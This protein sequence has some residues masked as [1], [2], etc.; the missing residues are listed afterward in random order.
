MTEI[1]FY[2]LRRKTL[3]EALPVILERALGRDG[4]VLVL[5]GS[6]ER[7]EALSAWLWTFRENSF[8]PHGT[9]RDGHDSRQPI[10]LTHE[11]VNPNAAKVLVQCDGAT[12][13]QVG[14]FTLVCDLFD[15]NDPSAVAAA[16]ERWR[17]HKDQGRQLVYF[18]QDSAGKWQQKAPA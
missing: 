6:A 4:R 11:S 10:Y 15:G 12:W 13:G 9:A 5:V 8:L 14:E 16:R 17:E 1:R 2:H 18:Q 7:A 3:E